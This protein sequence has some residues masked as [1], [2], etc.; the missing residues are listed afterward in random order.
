MTR[1]LTC[2]EAAAELRVGY[3]TL[4][5]LVAAGLVQHHRMPG[6]GKI[7]YFTDEDLAAIDA[8]AK[9]QPEKSLRLVR[10]TSAKSA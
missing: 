10:R 5:R 8:A 4:K 7:V 1:R 9:R 6:A 3:D 2:K